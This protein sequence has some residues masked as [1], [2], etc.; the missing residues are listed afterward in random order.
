[1]TPRL[2]RAPVWRA[3]RALLAES[4]YA[5][6]GGVLQIAPPGNSA[7]F[8]KLL[9]AAAKKSGKDSESPAFATA[10][11]GTAVAQVCP[12]K[13]DSV[14]AQ[15]ETLRR[16]FAPL[17]GCDSVAVDIRLPEAAAAAVFAALAGASRMPG[18]SRKACKILF[19]GCAPQ[20]AAES[21]AK[22]EAN[23]LARALCRLPPNILSLPVFAKTASALGKQRGLGVKVFDSKQLANMGAGA[24]LAV[25][26]GSVVQPQIVRLRYRPSG[27]KRRIILIGKG[28]CYDTGGVNAKPARHMRGMKGDMAGA[29]VALGAVL[30][31][32]E[33]GIPAQIDAYLAL[34][35]NGIG[36]AA[37]RPDEEITALSGKRIEIVHSD[38]EGRMILADALTLATREQPRA[39]AV[40]TFATLTGTMHAALGNRMSGVFACGE[41]WLARAMRAAEASGE[42]LCTFPLPADYRRAL[43]SD[44]AD[45]KQCAEEGEAD[46]IMAALFL[47]EFMEGAPPW[48]HLDLSAASCKEG[49]GAMPGPETGFGAA[50]AMELLK[51][52][53]QP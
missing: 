8:G 22:A 10:P 50:W 52:A 36:P 37:Y 26:R 12:R 44:V 18:D 14:F 49:L 11:G 48:L 38:A 23:A 30:G 46:H 53:A 3:R 27:A 31:A 2:H 21:A 17:C 1:M 4:D 33:R 15:L 9:A 6:F 13:N 25:G 19:A 20:T 28:V 24:I 34:A 5:R 42:R 32:A 47:R 29:A 40:I 45:I 7:P 16:G 35:E 41:Q 51:A 39:D 43:K